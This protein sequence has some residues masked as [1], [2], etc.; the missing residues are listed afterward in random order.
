[1]NGDLGDGL[2]IVLFC[3]IYITCNN[4][5]LE[6]F[7][8][9]LWWLDNPCPERCRSNLSAKGHD[10]EQP[11]ESAEMGRNHEKRDGTVRNGIVRKALRICQPDDLC[12]PEVLFWAVIKRI[13]VLVMV[14]VYTSP[15]WWFLWSQG[16]SHLW[17]KSWGVWGI[18]IFK[19]LT[20]LDEEVLSKLARSS[21]WGDHRWL[22]NWSPNKTSAR[23][24]V[25]N[26][27]PCPSS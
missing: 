11:L 10:K 5:G 15:H 27:Q 21:S 7:W 12:Y 4:S 2:L 9:N 14:P 1:M 20:L 16:P 26:F 17:Y 23:C 3:F 13:I 8:L 18:A 19:Q 25:S 24:A 6:F 22:L